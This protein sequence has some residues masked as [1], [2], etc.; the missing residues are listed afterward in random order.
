M[1][2]DR[3]SDGIR[4][5]SARIPTH[6]GGGRKGTRGRSTREGCRGRGKK[7]WPVGRSSSGSGYHLHGGWVVV[8]VHNAFAVCCRA[9]RP[10]NQ[11]FFFFE[12]VS[13]AGT[14]KRK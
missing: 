11:S 7:A 9:T 10:I 13:V 12:K 3:D 5:D 4:K 14:H 8:V 2:D 1:V 6:G